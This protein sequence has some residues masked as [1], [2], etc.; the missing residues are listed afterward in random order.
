MKSQRLL[1]MMSLLQ[2]RRLTSPPEA[3]V[4]WRHAPDQVTSQPSR[5]PSIRQSERRATG[6]E[7]ATL[8]VDST[9]PTGALDP[10]TGMGFFATNR[11]FA[12]V[13]EF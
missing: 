3:D 6:H 1:E 11:E 10:Y 12:Y 8:D 4:P 7:R 2:M 9:S 13:L 5:V